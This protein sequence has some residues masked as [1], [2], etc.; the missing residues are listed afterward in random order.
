MKRIFG[1]LKSRHFCFCLQDLTMK[2]PLHRKKLQLSIKTI[3]SKTVEKSAELDYIW[4]TRM[5][6]STFSYFHTNTHKNPIV[7]LRLMFK[8][9]FVLGWL[10]DIGLPQYKD[11][12]NESRVD[13]QVLQYLTVVSLEQKML[14]SQCKAF[15]STC[16]QFFRI[17][18]DP[19]NF[20]SSFNIHL[21]LLPILEWLVIP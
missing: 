18:S 2:N 13:G 21:F 9:I 17:V 20:H 1:Q 5:Y 19:P 6:W 10:D 12:F 16:V 11:Q 14:N 7:C 8:C 3:S 4:V 15:M